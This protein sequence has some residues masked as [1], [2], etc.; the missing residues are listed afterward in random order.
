MKTTL[1]RGAAATALAL[2]LGA[3]AFAQDPSG[4]VGAAVTNTQFDTPFGDD[5]VNGYKLGGTYFNNLGTW[6]LQASAAYNYL[7]AEPEEVDGFGGELD[8][9]LRDSSSHAL[10]GFVSV[11]DSEDSTLW[12]VGGEGQLFRD[13]WTFGGTAGWFDG[14]DTFDSLYG[15]C[16]FGRLYGS[17]NFA[18]EGRANLANVDYGV[19]DQD[20]YGFGA[21]AEYQFAGSPFSV[22]GDVDYASADDVDVD[23]TTLM[24]GGRWHFGTADLVTRDREG[25]GMEGASCISG[26]ASL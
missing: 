17:D 8:L 14:D 24:L 7:D 19:G 6:N 22:T 16:A 23:A 2:M 13:A 26:A 21:G 20:V 12:G 5:D 11:V 18:V 3:G 25:A 10:G 15:A 4:Y 9:F 1:M